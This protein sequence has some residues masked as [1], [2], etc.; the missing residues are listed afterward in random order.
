LELVTDAIFSE[1][2]SEQD[3]AE[4]IWQLD[5][6]DTDAVVPALQDFVAGDAR[7]QNRSL[8]TE[9]IVA[10]LDHKDESVVGLAES[11]LL[12]ENSSY[13][14]SNLLFALTRA[15]PPSR[16]IPILAE[17][18]TLSPGEMRTSAAV[19]MYQTDS[20]RGIPP[21]LRALDDPDPGVAFAVMQGLGNLTKDYEWR[22]TS[23]ELDADWFP[24]LNHCRDFRQRR[25]G[26]R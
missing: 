18:F 3:K 19:A 24:C 4:A 23:V 6:A 15:I 25:T 8:Q 22:P 26:A 2:V 7:R 1:K 12:S 13:W 9:A 17:A 10:L 21:L 20:I 11:E 14:N 16:S 5:A